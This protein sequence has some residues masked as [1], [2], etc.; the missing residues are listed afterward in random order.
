MSMHFD[1]EICSV[2]N[3]PKLERAIRLGARVLIAPTNVRMRFWVS[4]DLT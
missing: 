4:R 2:V 1:S 3:V